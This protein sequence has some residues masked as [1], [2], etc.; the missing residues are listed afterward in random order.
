M[1]ANVET[2]VYSN[3]PAW[4]GEGVVLDSNGEKGL[5]VEQAIPASGLDWTV[6]KVPCFAKFEGKQMLIEDRFAVQR[7]T[8]GR[9][10]G[11]V[12]ATWEPFQN[13][14][15]FELVN[16]LVAQ[17][18]AGLGATWIEA[19]GALDGGKKVWLLVH[20]GGDLMIADEAIDQYLLMTNG[21]DGRT[22]VTAATTNVR[23]VCQNTLTLA[24]GTAQRV[25]R[26]RHTNK[27]AERVKEAAHILGMRNQYAEQQAIQGEY[28]AE[29]T[30]DEGKFDE[31]LRSLMPITEKNDGKPAGTMIQGRRDSIRH[32]YMTAPNLDNIRGTRWAALNAVIEYSDYGIERKD[33]NV[34]LKTQWGINATP[35][36]DEAFTILKDPKLSPI[37][38]D[39][40]AIVA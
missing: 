9:V 3:K 19:G 32:L 37:G 35:L 10:F 28:L 34:Q 14:A 17:A 31:F 36:K 39:K 20:I 5:T 22:S 13:L 30:M 18:S 11:T 4:H 27:A 12:G 23:V 16:D 6:E 15:G 8:D 25:V 1:P 7:T 29:Q 21:H 38:I 40:A 33:A 2:A 26:V 24:L